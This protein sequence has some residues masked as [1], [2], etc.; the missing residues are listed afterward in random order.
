MHVK[1]V[2]RRARSLI[3]TIAATVLWLNALL[4]FPVTRPSVAAIANRLRLDL[5]ETSIL[6]VLA[7]LSLLYSYGWTRFAL[8]LLYIYAFPF[9]LLFKLARF[10]SLSL[11][12]TTTRDPQTVTT[13][14]K[15]ASVMPEP[16]LVRRSWNWRMGLKRLAKPFTSY[17]LLWC[18]LIVLASRRA[19]LWLSL[20]IVIAHLAR[21]VVRGIRL[22]TMSHGWLRSL[23][24]LLRSHADRLIVAVVAAP[25]NAKDKPTEDAIRSLVG[26]QLGIGL[27]K[28]R[29]RTTQIFIGASLLIFI[30]AYIYVGII[31]GFLYYGL[32]RIQSIPY[33]WAEALV[34]SLFIPAAFGDLPRN[35]WIKFFGGVHWLLVVVAGLSTFVAYMQKR[36]NSIYRVV[37]DLSIR[38]A[39]EELSRKLAQFNEKLR[40]GG[41]SE[42]LT[43]GETGERDVANQ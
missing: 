33:T 15:S 10:V 1:D 18:L 3:R 8:D 26:L 14:A 32:A 34:T 22:G 37:D 28:N 9:V 23:E 39:D 13:T 2:L 42:N 24:D 43:T 30:G 4:L 38:L 17:T 11:I 5:G 7:C 20:F 40:Q 12:R 36:L 27:L 6:I 41:T 16:R 35:A 31:F 19:L 21:A 25:E 29:Q